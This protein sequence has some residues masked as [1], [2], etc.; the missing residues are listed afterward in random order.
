MLLAFHQRD[1]V[2]LWESH[3]NAAIHER[4][5]SRNPAIDRPD[6]RNTSWL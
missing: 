4:Q 6:G 1:R 3:R 5:G 2:T